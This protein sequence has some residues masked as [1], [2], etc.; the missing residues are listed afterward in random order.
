[1]CGSTES[2]KGLTDDLLA[3][4]DPYQAEEIDGVS[5]QEVELRQASCRNVTHDGDRFTFDTI[6]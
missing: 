3:S 1:M 4:V 2:M 6:A 5:T